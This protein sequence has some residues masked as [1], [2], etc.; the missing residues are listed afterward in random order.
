MLLILFK[1][2]L[3]APW[4]NQC[5]PMPTST[6][7]ARATNVYGTI[8][9]VVPYIRLPV[10]SVGKKSG[11]A[12]SALPFFFL[13]TN[14]KKHQRKSIM[15]HIFLAL[16][17]EEGL[18]TEN[19]NTL[20]FAEIMIHSMYAAAPI[21]SFLFVDGPRDPSRVVPGSDPSRGM[22]YCE[23]PPPPRRT[24]HPPHTH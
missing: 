23:Y 16:H 17:R 1:G 24:P 8:H 5:L 3:R 19:K 6:P 9:H 15:H 14:M 22:R 18:F 20:R 12:S 10:P 4:S 7:K 2:C 21:H 11:G 13:E